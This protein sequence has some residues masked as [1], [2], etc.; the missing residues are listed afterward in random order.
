MKTQYQ[1]A[2]REPIITSILD[3]D[4]YQL[5]MGQFAFRRYPN[6]EVKY[7]HKNRTAGVILADVIDERLLR[8]ELDNIRGLRA[9]EK[10]IEYLRGLKNNGQPLFGED[11]LNFLRNPQLPDYTLE[12][13]DGEYK[14]EFDGPWASGIMCETPDLAVINELYY[15]AITKGQDTGNILAEGRRRLEEKI[16]ILHQNPGIRFMEF[17][18]RRRYSKYW[19]DEVVRMLMKNTPDNMIGTSNVYLAMK[20]G[21]NP[22]G[23][24]AHQAFMVMSG[25]MHGSDE[26]IRAS[27]N[28][29]LQQWWED[30][31]QGLSIALTD[32]YGTEFFFKD[33]TDEQARNWKGL[34][35][36]SGDSAKFAERQIA[37]YKEGGIDPKTKLFV[38]SDGLDLQKI[39]YLHNRFSNQINVVAGWGTNLTNDMGLKPLSM[40]IKAI[41]ANNYWLVKLSDN[42]AKATGRPEDIARITRIF[43]YDPTKYQKEEC[44]Y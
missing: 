20:Y 33:F 16:E 4:M 22:M 18:T 2:E 7:A 26:E 12:R 19:Q 35:Q 9:T 11:Y 8:R 15:R 32:T 21:L 10:E 23:T 29:F 41:M 44:R 31:G 6:I 36:D 24:H 1:E 40:V 27:H 17:G 43:E 5:T 34:R 28:A 13:R 39:I 14:L 3:T 38:P 30:Y 37:F 42:L 25:I